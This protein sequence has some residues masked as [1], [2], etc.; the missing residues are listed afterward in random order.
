MKKHLLLT[1]VLIVTAF[2]IGAC[3]NRKCK[4]CPSAC[5]GVSAPAYYK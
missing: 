1:T 3:K 5:A 2:A 4:K